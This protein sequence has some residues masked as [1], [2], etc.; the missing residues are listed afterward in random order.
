MIFLSSL[1][2]YS[3]IEL[4]NKVL[5]FGTLLPVESANIYIKGTTIGTISNVDGRFLLIAPQQHKNDTLVI[6]SIGYKSF[7]TPVG[8]FDNTIE[9]YLFRRGYCFFR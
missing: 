8:E 4:T 3:Q 1:A 2:T 9:I 7:K 5:D 6:S